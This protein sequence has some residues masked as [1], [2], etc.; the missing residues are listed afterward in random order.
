ML[1]CTTNLIFSLLFGISAITT[2]GFMYTVFLLVTYLTC[3]IDFFSQ[4]TLTCAIEIIL[5]YWKPNSWSFSTEHKSAKS[6]RTQKLCF[7]FLRS[8]IWIQSINIWIFINI[9]IYLAAVSKRRHLLAKT[10]AKHWVYRH[11][12]IG[13]CR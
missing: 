7:T 9:V 4:N 5:S 2:D 6:H 13:K 8:A 10:T 1:Q 12:V 11:F 3:S